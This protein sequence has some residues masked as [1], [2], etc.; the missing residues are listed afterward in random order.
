MS[1]SLRMRAMTESPRRPTMEEI[2]KYVGAEN[3]LSSRLGMSMPNLADQRLLNVPVRQTSIGT[4]PFQ[5]GE[6]T[7]L[8]F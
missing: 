2:R 5:S 3:G 7:W 8:N 6:E 4:V 1:L